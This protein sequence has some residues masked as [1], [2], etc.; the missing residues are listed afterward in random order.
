[1]WLT[2]HVSVFVTSYFHAAVQALCGLPLGAGV[3]RPLPIMWLHLMIW[4]LDE[5]KKVYRC[6]VVHSHCCQI[7]A[8]VNAWLP[9]CIRLCVLAKGAYCGHFAM[10]P[11]VCIPIV[12]GFPQCMEESFNIGKVAPMQWKVSNVSTCSTYF[13]VVC[14]ARTSPS[15]LF[16]LVQGVGKGMIA[17][18]I[19][20]NAYA[21]V[22]LLHGNV[23]LVIFWHGSSEITKPTQV[24]QL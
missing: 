2:L 12:E 8:V 7:Y 22:N 21:H 16:K 19:I 14:H 15:R 5:V 23:K 20:L 6:I 9:L 24:E 13:L 4:K 17:F 10:Q 11:Y 1:M 18:T 3:F